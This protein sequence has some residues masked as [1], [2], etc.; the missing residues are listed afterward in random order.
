MIKFSIRCVSFVLFVLVI[1]LPGSLV[2]AHD[3]PCPET[4]ELTAEETFKQ[5][6]GC[7]TLLET[8]LPKLIEVTRKSALAGGAPEAGRSEL[9]SV[10]GNNTTGE[11]SYQPGDTFQ[12]CSECPELVVIPPGAFMMGAP[13]WEEESGDVER[14]VHQV[15]IAYSFAV[16]KYEITFAEWDACVSAGGCSHT[17]HD[18]GWGRGRRPVIHVIWEDAQEYV[19][20]LSEKTGHPYRLPSESEWEYMA[21]AGT[22]TP[23][24]TGESITPEHANFR[25]LGSYGSYLGRGLYRQETVEV[26]S[27]MANDFGL[28]DVHGNVW[29]WVQDCWHNS[30]EG[31]PND[32]SAWEYDEC[33]YRVLRGGSWLWSPRNLRSAWR[34]GFMSDLRNIDI[35]FR[36]IR[37]LTP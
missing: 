4:T 34:G 5:Y 11:I 21:R 10:T 37:V 20:W 28:H 24:H 7:L 12:D 9:E 29:E 23:F 32:G 36:V 8:L 30:Y 22:T 17:P 13:E 26:G 27:F 19:Q 3:T 2:M 15:R 14:P 16:G 6:P 33:G 31:A 1:S 25:G 35:G 18:E